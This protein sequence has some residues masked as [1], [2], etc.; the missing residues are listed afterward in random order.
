M[1][2]VVRVILELDGQNQHGENLMS[3]SFSVTACH[4]VMFKAE[5]FLIRTK[6]PSYGLHKFDPSTGKKVEEYLESDIDYES[7][8][9][10]NGFGC[11]T[12]TDGKEVFIGRCSK[13]VWISEGENDYV[14]LSTLTD[15]EVGT[16]AKFCTDILMVVP[17]QQLGM[18]SVGSCSY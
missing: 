18:W 11:C 8:A 1:Q 7:L 13:S 14:A 16:L 10:Q 6:N 17:D 15:E 5:S 4:G 2:T 3:A 12:T 9:K